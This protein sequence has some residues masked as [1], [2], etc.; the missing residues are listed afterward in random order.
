MLNKLI[1]RLSV[2][3]PAY[4]TLVLSPMLKYMKCLPEKEQLEHLNQYYNTDIPCDDSDQWIETFMV[5]VYPYLN[6]S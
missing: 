1:T 2:E 4:C 3:Q 5:E 6:F